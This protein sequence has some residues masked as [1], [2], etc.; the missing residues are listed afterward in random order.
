MITKSIYDNI[1]DKD[2]DQKKLISG[3]ELNHEY[4]YLIRT[5]TWV[6]EYL[7]LK[8]SFKQEKATFYK[9]NY[10]KLSFTYIFSPAYYIDDW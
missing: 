9:Y 6:R 4:S 8:Q 1:Y 2:D 5:M 7:P 10:F 3:K